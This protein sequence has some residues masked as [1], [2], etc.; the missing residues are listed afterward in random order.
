MALDKVMG[1]AQQ[2]MLRVKGGARKVVEGGQY[3]KL[4]LGGHND[5][6]LLM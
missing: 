2:G 1:K 5:F 4:I 3:M 6:K